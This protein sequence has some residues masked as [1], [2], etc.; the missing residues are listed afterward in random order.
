MTKFLVI[1]LTLYTAMHA[2][3]YMRVRALLSERRSFHVL[4]I[5]FLLL[6]IVA[7]IISRL[8][9]RNGYESAAKYLAVVAFNW[10]GFIFLA[11]CG[12]PFVS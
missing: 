5:L 2:V 6:M 8:L 11:F 10:T 7:P 1:F 9:E 4:F 3:F 12:A